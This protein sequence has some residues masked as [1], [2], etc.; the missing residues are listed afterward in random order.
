MVKKTN[1][2]KNK[3][4][5][6]CEENPCPDYSSLL[7]N[8]NRIGGQVEGIKKM[9]ADRRYCPDIII[10]LRAIR[11]AISS[12]E[13]KVMEGYLNSCVTDAFNSDNEKDKQQ[14]IAE[15]TDLYKRFN[16]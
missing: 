5:D 3:Q 10:Q 11:S 4:Q 6:C 14:K 1:K 8:I 16:G 13:S 15:L 9:I 12:I 2:T 7:P